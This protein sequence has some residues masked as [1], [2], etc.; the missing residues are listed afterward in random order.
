[1]N[2]S[3]DSG[4]ESDLKRKEESIRSAGMVAREAAGKRAQ[5]LEVAARGEGEEPEVAWALEWMERKR[6]PPGVR[7]GAGQWAK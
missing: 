2:P 3:P 5:A 4:R 6:R 7:V 1:M